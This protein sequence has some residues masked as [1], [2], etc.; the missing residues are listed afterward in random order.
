ME[1]R[2]GGATN[3]VKS[4]MKLLEIE[5]DLWSIVWFVTRSAYSVLEDG[6]EAA[7]TGRA[8]RK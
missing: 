4:F 8:G 6:P 1:S 3:I 5:L 7:K 2:Q